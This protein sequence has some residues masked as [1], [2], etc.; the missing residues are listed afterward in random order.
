MIQIIL[1]DG[2]IEEKPIKIHNNM[3]V[4][5]KYNDPTRQGDTFDKGRNLAPTRTI[6]VQDNFGNIIFENTEDNPYYWG[7]ERIEKEFDEY[8]QEAFENME[9]DGIQ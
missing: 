8:L 9:E 5:V 3:L 6:I 1:G 7:E 2:L 4:L